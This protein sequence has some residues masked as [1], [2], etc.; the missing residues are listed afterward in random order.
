MGVPGER[1]KELKETLPKGSQ[2]PILHATTGDKTEMMFQSRAILRY[3]GS[4]GSYKGSKLYPTKPL[5]RFYCDEI[6]EMVEDV[7]SPMPATFSIAD[8]KE[9][10]AARLALVTAP[11]GP[12][13]KTLMKL[14]KRL[15]MFPWAAGDKPTIADAYL[16]IVCFM[17]Q[18]PTFLDGFPPDT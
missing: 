12:C 3:I 6:I 17:F 8:Q 1:W 15:E 16:V 18:A 4:I 10:E 9:K 2:M 7:R 11:D 14:N 5:E 13:Y